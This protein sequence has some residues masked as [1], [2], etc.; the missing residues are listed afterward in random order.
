MLIILLGAVM[1]IY[2]K[3]FWFL[4]YGWLFREAEM[5]TAANV[6]FRGIGIVIVVVGIEML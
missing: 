2:P 4:R 5:S 3:F 6:A 1:L